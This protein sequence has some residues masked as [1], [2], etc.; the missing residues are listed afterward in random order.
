MPDS[1]KSIASAAARFSADT[2]LPGSGAPSRR[3]L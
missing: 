3:A 2:V 1:A